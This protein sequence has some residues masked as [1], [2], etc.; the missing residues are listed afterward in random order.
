[1][2]QRHVYRARH[3]IE[4]RV[5]GA[6]ATLVARRSS[7][8]RQRLTFRLTGRLSPMSRSLA[9]LVSGEDVELMIEVLTVDAQ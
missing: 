4:L 1:V 2:G 7:P 6:D 9:Y 8:L 5:E 3:E